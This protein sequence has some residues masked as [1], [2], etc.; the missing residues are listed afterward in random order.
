MKS[1][2][3]YRNFKRRNRSNR[4]RV[5]KIR[6]FQIS[7]RN[8]NRV[9]LQK[10]GDPIEIA[11]K[12]KFLQKP[13][14]GLT[15]TRHSSELSE[16]SDATFLEDAFA[17]ASISS[18]IPAT[19]FLNS[20]TLRPRERM[21]EGR[22]F[23]KRRNAMSAIITSWMGDPT[24]ANMREDMGRPFIKTASAPGNVSI[25]GK[26]VISLAIRRTFDDT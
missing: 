21:T 4:G 17:A 20:V 8:S 7:I 22:R 19:P 26:V 15:K 16:L 24:I 14:V 23:P 3:L 13:L 18:S 12:R 9:L 25:T 1:E 2:S 10:N 11:V 6:F 5:L